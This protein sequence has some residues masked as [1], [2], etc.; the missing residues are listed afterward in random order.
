MKK[1]MI[2]LA[3]VF[4]L[5]VTQS[6]QA[7]VQ[8]AA[9]DSQYAS[10]ESPERESLI[11][12][13]L[14]LIGLREEAQT[15]LEKLRSR[16][17]SGE[18]GRPMPF[19]KVDLATTGPAVQTWVAGQKPIPGV[20]SAMIEGK[21]YILV[22]RGEKPNPGYGIGIRNVIE[23][24]DR[25]VVQVDLRNPEPGMMYAQVITTPIDVVEIPQTNK[26]VVLENMIE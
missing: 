13:I 26:P 25:L 2:A 19:Q 9:G 22:S 10:N 5:S 21:T 1:P 14:N 17:E 7:Q 3:I 4:A 18:R 24:P 23:E 6:S 15:L 20:H 8:Q 12:K 16:M 11:E